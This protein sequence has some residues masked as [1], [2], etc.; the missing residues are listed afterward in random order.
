MDRSSKLH[1]S[2]KIDA[3]EICIYRPAHKKPPF[4]KWFAAL[5]NKKAQQVIQAR[6]DRAAFGNLGDSKSV[7][8]GIFEFR[9][10]WGPGYRIYF[11][12]IDKKIILLLIGG[13]KRTQNQDIE[14][15]RKYLKDWKENG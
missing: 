11:S 13:D 8:F 1:Y 3:Y 6:I 4:E 7:G 9:I 15:A 12:I 2:G 10:H 5:K 14:K